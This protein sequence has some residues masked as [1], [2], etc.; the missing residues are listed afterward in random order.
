MV[1]H[2]SMRD[3]T[4]HH[5]IKLLWVNSDM[6]DDLNYHQAVQCCAVSSVHVLPAEAWKKFGFLLLLNYGIPLY[7]EV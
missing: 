3:I 2:N 1:F 5:A 4:E 6:V 7:I